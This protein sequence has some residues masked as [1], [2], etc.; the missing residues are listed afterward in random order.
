MRAPEFWNHKHGS[1][2]APLTR[3]L[4]MPLSWLV[5]LAGRWRQRRVKPTRVNIPVICLGNVTLGGTG[6]TPLAITLC[7]ALQKAGYNPAFLTRGYGGKAKGP[8][9]VDK[10]HHSALDVGDEALL[11]ISHAPVIVSRDRVA[12]AKIAV[13]QGASII[14]MDDGFQN[15]YLTKDV[16]L[17]VL[18]TGGGIGN[19][20]VFPAGPLREPLGDALARA[21]A[22]IAIGTGSLKQNPDLPVLT[23]RLVNP[24]PPPKGSLLAF[25]GIG[26]PQKFFDALRD[27]GADLVQEIAF[28]DHH[29]YR[30]A[31]ITRL[32]NWAHEENATLVTTQKDFVRLA[33]DQRTGIHAWPVEARFDDPQIL[34]ATLK[35]LW[36]QASRS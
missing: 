26:R 23:V 5:I 21:D 16:S 22:V 6:K 3:A 4:L 17:L 8:L 15:P 32:R 18:E 14:I 35:P 20:R 7:K 34:M 31:E 25:A 11:L 33:E 12:G 13:M 29:L 27:C 2:S 30:P 1:L 9:S 28:D 19:G 36:E 10:A 24:V